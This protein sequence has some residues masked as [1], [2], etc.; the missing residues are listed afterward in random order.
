MICRKRD[1][2][3]R[4]W[5]S[6]CVTLSRKPGREQNRVFTGCGADQR[7]VVFGIYSP[8]AL[9]LPVDVNIRWRCWMSRSPLGWLMIR[10]AHGNHLDQATADATLLLRVVGVNL[11]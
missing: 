8:R 11:R 7:V 1:T 5:R 3:F 9:E 4:S 2:S 6:P 10:L